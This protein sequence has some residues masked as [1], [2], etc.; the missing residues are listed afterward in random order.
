MKQ[1]QDK[2]I[3]S[4]ADAINK[5]IKLEVDKSGAED[6]LAEYPP[7]TSPEMRESKMEDLKEELAAEKEKAAMRR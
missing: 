5:A 4:K 7:E 1:K 6:A 2:D 3:A